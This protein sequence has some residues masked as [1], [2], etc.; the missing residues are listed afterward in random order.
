M[1]AQIPLSPLDTDR[2][3]DVL[4]LGEALIEFNQVQ[5]DPP[6]YLQGFG[7]DT[8]NAIIAAARAGARTAYLTRLG[9]DGWADRLLQLWQTE[10]VDTKGVRRMAGQRTGL[11]FVHHDERGHHF[12]YARAGSAASLM[13]VQ[14]VQTHWADLIAQSHW[15][16]VSGISLAISDSARQAA[17]AA[18]QL[19]RQRRTRVAL[20]TNLRLSLWSLAQARETLIQAMAHCDLLLP[21][22]EDM[23]QLLGPMEPEAIAHWC[24]QQGV[25]TV[26]L[27]LGAQGAMISQAGEVW[28]VEG[29][30]VNAI[31]AT[32]AGDCFCGNLLARWVAGDDLIQAVTW[33]NA[34]AA[35]SVQGHGAI[36]PLPQAEQVRRCLTPM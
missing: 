24:H 10:G 23:V 12:S 4:A 31:D 1:A 22:L 3:L 17:L 36:A 5:A 2:A 14:D 6:M 19:A 21:S 20:D 29:R 33:A 35:L 16:H 28:R 8:S 7:G 25:A 18:M 15:L 30:S 32:G 11:Y 13:S 9:D 27:K 26:V 34:A